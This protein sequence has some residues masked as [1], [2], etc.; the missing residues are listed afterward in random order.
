MDSKKD[1]RPAMPQQADAE[2]RRDFL[3]RVGKASAAAPSAAL[4]LAAADKA[5]AHVPPSGGS[6]SS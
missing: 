3:K 6:G 4:L 2:A 5:E 1:A